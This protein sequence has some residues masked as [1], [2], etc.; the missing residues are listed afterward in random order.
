[1]AKI[2]YKTNETIA[3]SIIEPKAEMDEQ[4]ELGRTAGHDLSAGFVIQTDSQ[5]KV[6]WVARCPNCDHDVTMWPSGLVYSILSDGCE[7]KP[8]Y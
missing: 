7:G 8:G 1:M 2:I 4:L 6:C 5:D 3:V